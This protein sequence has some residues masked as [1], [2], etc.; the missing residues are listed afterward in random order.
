MSEEDIC[1]ERDKAEEAADKLAYAIGEYFGTGV[2]DHSSLNN[3]WYTALALIRRHTE[4][5]N[6]CVERF[7]GKTN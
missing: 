6:E 5:K 1:K 2:G 4:L 3:P 7:R